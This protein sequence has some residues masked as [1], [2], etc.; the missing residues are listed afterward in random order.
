MF[1]LNVVYIGS[2]RDQFDKLLSPL[3][4]AAQPLAQNI[5]TIDWNNITKVAFFG[6]ESSVPN[7][8]EVEKGLGYNVFGGAIQT[9]DIPTYTQFFKDF[10][11]LMTANPGAQSSVFFIEFFSKRKI[12]ETPANGTSYPWRNITAHL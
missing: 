2:N 3:L 9:W 6:A 4:A 11:S 1:D 8:C 10:E 12:L 7:P 5:S